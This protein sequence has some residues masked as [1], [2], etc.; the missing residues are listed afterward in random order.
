MNEKRLKQLEALLKKADGPMS[1]EETK[2]VRRAVRELQLRGMIGRP[3]A[4]IAAIRQS[5]KNAEDL[6]YVE[7]GVDEGLMK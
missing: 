5:A 2:L 4:R 7:F 6:D 1:A 3:S